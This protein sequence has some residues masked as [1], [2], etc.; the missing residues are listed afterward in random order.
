VLDKQYIESGQVLLAFRHLPL[1]IHKRAEEAAEAA[2]CAARH[3]KFW[4]MHD[5]LFQDR[6]RLADAD[7]TRYAAQIGLEPAGFQTCMKSVTTPKVRADL[8]AAEALGISSTPTFLL[9][10]LEASSAVRVKHRISGAR[11]V[12]DFQKALDALLAQERQ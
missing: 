2:E 9:G 7:L 11:P 1:P 6:R 8:A 12:E 4:E 10:T 5:L 3:G